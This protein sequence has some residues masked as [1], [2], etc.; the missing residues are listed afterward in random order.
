MII[1]FEK[2]EDHKKFSRM[3]SRIYPQ[4]FFKLTGG[5]YDVEIF[6]LICN[7]IAACLDMICAI[8]NIVKT[9]PS[10]KT[11]LIQTM[12]QVHFASR[13]Q[14]LNENYK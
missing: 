14:I 10:H 4:R 6:A 12:K 13:V 3:L 1:S 5:W 8:E 7:R 9:N 11:W 2:I